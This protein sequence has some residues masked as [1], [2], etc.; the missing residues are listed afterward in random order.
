MSI[1]INIVTFILFFGLLIFIHEFGHYLM[2]RLTKVK[3]EEFGFGF[4]IPNRPP[5]WHMFRYAGT[6]FTLN[7]IPFGGFVRL[8]GET[9]PDVTDGFMTAAPLSRILVML[10]GPLMNFIAGILLFAMVFSRVGASDVK[11]VQLI[12]IAENSP[13]MSAGLLADDIV[14]AVN[15]TEVSGTNQLIAII[16]DNLGVPVTLTINR[17]GET[18]ET[19]LTPR[20]N[21]PEGE[22]PLGVMLGNPVKPISYLEAIPYGAQVTFEQCRQIILLPAQL[23]EGTVNSDEA[24]MLGPKGIYD[25]YA[26]MRERDEAA[27]ASPDPVEQSLAVNTLWFAATLSIAL[28]LTNLLPLPALD[29]GRILFVLPELILRRRVPAELENMVHVIGFGILMLVMV[30]ITAQ[31]I[32]NPVVLP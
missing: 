28:G 3:V 29:G 15:G 14:V 5:L 11:T 16:N 31:D 4:P 10:G 32:I 1:F 20:S 18:I 27:T 17:G 22:G 6:D 21:P 19:T 8:K 23:I 12:Q 25:V 13:A 30:F 26:Q 7:W 2:A 24:R 9:D